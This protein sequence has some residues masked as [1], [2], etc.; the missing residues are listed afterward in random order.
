[1]PVPVHSNTFSLTLAYSPITPLTNPTFAKIPSDTVLRTFTSLTAAAVPIAVLT[2]SG[3]NHP[4]YQYRLISGDNFEIVGDTT[5][6]LTAP[7]YGLYTA[8]VE[9]A[10][11]LVRRSRRCGGG[12]P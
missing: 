2:A 10:N 4:N 12:F 6:Q 1:M 7:G 11:D 3:G 9:F 5:L 8:T